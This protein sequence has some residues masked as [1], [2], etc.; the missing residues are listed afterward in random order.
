MGKPITMG[1][2]C[3]H[4]PVALAKA[5]AAMKDKPRIRRFNAG[6]WFF[7]VFLFV[8]ELAMQSCR[9][10]RTV[11]SRLLLSYPTHERPRVCTNRSNGPE[12]NPESE[13]T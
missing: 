12:V 1:L 11:C 10:R 4:A 2:G 7:I 6:R 3:A 5:A 9:L 8:V 13:A